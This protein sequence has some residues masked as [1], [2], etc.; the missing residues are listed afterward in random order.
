MEALGFN[1]PVLLAQLVN[2]SILLALLSALLYKPVMRALDER[3]RRIRESL[4]QAEAIRRRTEDCV[5]I[6]CSG[7]YR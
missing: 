7:V 2:F 6:A 1:I 5:E 4:E 3:T